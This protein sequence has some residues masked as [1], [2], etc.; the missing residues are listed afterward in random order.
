MQRPTSHADLTK[1][2]VEYVRVSSIQ[3]FPGWD[4][5]TVARL[6]EL[7]AILA[8]VAGGGDAVMLMDLHLGAA[9]PAARAPA[10]LAIEL[11]F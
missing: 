11:Q 3:P 8:Q 9:A 7:T 2:A 1:T 5:V 10:S 6:P 4:D